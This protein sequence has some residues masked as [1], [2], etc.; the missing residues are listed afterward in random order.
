VL[1]ELNDIDLIEYPVFDFSIEDMCLLFNKVG[2]I[3]F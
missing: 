3:I 2:L 1:I